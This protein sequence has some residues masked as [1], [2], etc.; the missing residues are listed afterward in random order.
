MV[1]ALSPAP[2][3]LLSD[4]NFPFTPPGND[5]HVGLRCL[6]SL[7]VKKKEKENEL[8]LRIP[9]LNIQS[10]LKSILFYLRNAEHFRVWGF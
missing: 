9:T 3:S 4:G 2:I 6:T 7:D 10:A 8:G 5:A 1:T